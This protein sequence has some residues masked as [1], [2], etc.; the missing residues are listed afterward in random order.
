MQD[1]G[2][3][4]V[5]GRRFQTAAAVAAFVLPTALL[6][7]IGLGSLREDTQRGAERYRARA[8]G[9]CA[10]LDV[11]LADE[12]IRAARLDDDAGSVMLDFDAE[13][14]VRTEFPPA[15]SPDA[16][17]DPTLLRA[18]TSE[19]DRLQAGGQAADAIARLEEVAGQSSDP[20]VTA[21]AL[22]ACAALQETSADFAAATKTRERLIAE[23]PEARNTRGLL[24]ALA[25]RRAL[26]GPVASEPDAWIELYRDA[27]ADLV[28]RDQTAAVQF[29]RE[30]RVALDESPERVRPSLAS[31]DATDAR[32]ALRRAVAATLRRGVTDWVARGAPGGRALF[33]APP[34]VIAA[35]NPLSIERADDPRAAAG[36]LWVVVEREGDGWRG[37]AGD[38][39]VLLDG[40]LAQLGADPAMRAEG[41][42]LR[43][44][45]IDDPPAQSLARRRL[46]APFDSFAVT[47][48][49]GD[50]ARFLDSERRRFL[51]S[52][53]LVVLAIASAAAGAWFTLR[54]VARE[55]DAARGREAFVAAVTHELKTPLASIRLFAEMLARGDV[56]PA[57]VSEFGRRTVSES[58][59]LARLVDS[60]LDSARIEQSSDDLATARVELDG[61]VARARGVVD[62]LASERG[63]EIRVSPRTEPCV[64]VGDAEALVRAVVNLLDN[65]MKYSPQG[66][67][68]DV[69]L[70]REGSSC[71]LRV[72]DRG[73]GVPEADRQRIFEPFRRL[74]DE[75]R[76]EAPGVGLGLALVAKIA[77]AHAGSARCL[78]REG[79]GSC[80]E[81]RLP[82]APAEAIA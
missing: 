26:L 17:S 32:A 82:A 21:W 63:C 61:V 10:S 74:G 37:V 20:A 50:F 69:E 24:R 23:H 58:D 79:G 52:A 51:F 30:L 44:S 1:R 15:P 60:V 66:S 11:A 41:F 29:A 73:R 43:V 80:F 71:V 12:L 77:A 68:I 5:V 72:L 14:S 45:P 13:G 9:L 64:V 4:R 62:G 33:A 2:K 16:P 46:Q 59:R 19:L 34:P 38:A 78:P 49:G 57:K 40:V 22:D 25:A 8:E 53:S 18:L 7:W 67:A 55:V 42:E 3:A 56:E 35:A 81:L 47:V 65:A 75:S 31:V 39:A 6:A 54:G 48:G 27:C 76:R 70:V 28:S 36:W